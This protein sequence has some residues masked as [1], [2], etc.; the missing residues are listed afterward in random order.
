[1]RDVLS[2]IEVIAITVIVGG[3]MA[4]NA[5]VLYSWQ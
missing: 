5:W 3:L 2:Y 1:M 4:G